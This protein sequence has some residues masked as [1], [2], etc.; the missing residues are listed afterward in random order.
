MDSVKVALGSRGMT[1]E[2]AQQCVGIGRSGEPWWICRWW[3]LSWPHCL[4]AVFFGSFSH[5]LPAC[6]NV[7][8]L[9]FALTD[10][11]RVRG[12]PF[13]LTDWR[14]VREGGPLHE[15]VGRNYKGLNETRHW[16]HLNVL[17]GGCGWLWACY[18]TWHDSPS[19]EE[20]ECLDI[21]LHSRAIMVS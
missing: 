5:A 7:R 15:A 9:T 20:E 14:R 16:H 6:R 11:R 19:L 10:C 13:G 2:T 17:K 1:V 8:G 12:L 3:K 18:L 21:L 4:V